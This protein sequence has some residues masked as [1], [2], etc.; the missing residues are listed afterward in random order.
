MKL[1]L[2]TAQLGLAYGVNN[3]VGHL[4]DEQAYAV[5]ETA[6]FSGFT[7]LDTSTEYGLAVERIN[8]FLDNTSDFDVIWRPSADFGPTVY[9]VEEAEGVEEPM[10]MVPA[11]VLDGRMDNEIWR[12]QT[13]G[14]TV[15]V[16]SLLLQGLIACEP[17]DVP[18]GILGNHDLITA[19]EPYLSDLNVAAARWDMSVTEIAVRWAWQIHPDVAIFGAETPEQVRDIATAWR[20]GPLPRAAVDELLALREGIPEIVISPRMWGQRFD[21]T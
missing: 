10:L 6:Y 12:L 21:F 11:S 13:R 14:K 15:F 3:S 18:A 5:L 4:S 9:T 8:L 2:G 19:A 1:C 16:R 20:K 7:M 17:G